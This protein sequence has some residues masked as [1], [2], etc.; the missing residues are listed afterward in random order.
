MQAPLQTIEAQAVA[1]VCTRGFGDTLA[2]GVPAIEVG[3]RIDAHGNEAEPLETAALVEGIK[4]LPNMPRAI[5]VSLLFAPRNPVH[6]QQVR[7][8][9]RLAFPSVTV[10]CSHEQAHEGDQ[11]GA[12]LA[13]TLRAAGW[14]PAEAEAARI[15]AGDDAFAGQLDAVLARIAAVLA[16]KVSSPPP[17]EASPARAAIF[18]PDGRLLAEQRDAALF[19]S[20]VPAAQA[21]LAEFPAAAMQ[22]GDAYLLNDPWRGGSGLLDLVL[23]RPVFARLRVQALAACVLRHRDMGGVVPGSQP[24]DATSIHQEGLRIPPVR[25]YREGETEPSLLRLLCTNSRQP[26]ALANDLRAQWAALQAGDEVLQPLLTQGDFELQGDRA[27]Q[28]SEQALRSALQDAPDGEYR[29]ID[30]LEG[31][32]VSPDPLRIAVLLRKSGDSLTIDLSDC[33]LQA[34]GPSNAPRAAVAAAIA[35]L[36]RAIAPSAAPNAG[37]SV[38][39][40]LRIAPGTIVDPAFPAAVSGRATVAQALA[41]ALRGA[42]AQARPEQCGAPGAAA[43]TL[44]AFDGT[45]EGASWQLVDTIAPAA[46]GAPP[47]AAPVAQ[48]PGSPAIPA[49]AMEAQAPLRLERFTPRVDS[50]GA[51]LHP[52][53]PGFVRAYRLLAGQGTVFYRG[54]RH[55]TPAQGVAGGGSGA[56][57]VARIERADGS[58]ELLPAKARVRWRAGDLLVVETAG[59]GGWG[60]G[61]VRG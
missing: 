27:I 5:A 41:H 49:E 31:D 36:A 28:A 20:L 4:A 40:T 46:G 34:A 22:P 44:L 58:V 18:L 23:V 59:G 43:E 48:V 33:A 47:G 7:V 6:E 26:D 50:G 54:E 10:V 8:L 3:G 15:P 60:A 17:H 56:C 51:G 14:Q 24:P 57:A 11:E 9:L 35:A 39:I 19:C 12:R 53:A 13:A 1:L 25:L 16:D 55:R 52:G 30:T 2:P 38:P 21:I 42:W 45:H 61:E 32:G 37:L 29:C